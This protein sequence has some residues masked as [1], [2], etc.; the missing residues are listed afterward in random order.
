MFHFLCNF[1]VAI[2]FSTTDIY[3]DTRE[4]Y[5][6]LHAKSVISNV[7]EKW[8]GRPI[9]RNI[10]QYQISLWHKGRKQAVFRNIP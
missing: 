1:V 6:C 2:F 8:N 5:V 10:P 7:N 3:G 9:F 4:A